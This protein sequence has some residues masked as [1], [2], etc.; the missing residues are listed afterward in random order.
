VPLVKHIAT[1]ARIGLQK[2]AGRDLARALILS[3]EKIHHT[4]NT[5][6][7]NCR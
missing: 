6:A 2:T 5:D 4:C 1:I 3:R 7:W